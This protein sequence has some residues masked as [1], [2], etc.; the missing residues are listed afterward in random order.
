[1][2]DYLAMNNAW[3]TFDNIGNITGVHWKEPTAQSVIVATDVA[4]RMLDGVDPMHAFI[5]N[6]HQGVK[7]LDR[8]PLPDMAIPVFWNLVL[9]EENSWMS[10]FRT[11]KI[12][13]SISLCKPLPVFARLFAT[14]MHDPSWLIHTWD[15]NKMSPT[16]DCIDI[17]F[18]NAHLYSFFMS[19]VHEI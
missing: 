7:T 19:K 14:V 17:L 6:E 18:D 2:K 15:L 3:V 13:I 16:C 10:S 11:S 1:M 9:P 8:K 5:V 4:T 12:G